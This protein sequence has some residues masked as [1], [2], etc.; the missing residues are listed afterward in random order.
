MFLASKIQAGYNVGG[1]A[2]SCY[3]D[4]KIVC[5]ELYRFEVLSSSMKIVFGS[6]DCAGYS[7]FSS[8]DEADNILVVNAYVL[9]SLCCI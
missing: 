2:R 9:L 6:F 4:N 5:R 3:A 1:C 7:F 8:G